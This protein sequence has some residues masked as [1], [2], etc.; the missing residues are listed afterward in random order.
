MRRMMLGISQDFLGKQLGLTFQ[1]VQKYEKG[2]NRIGASRL[3][4]L[5]RIL[6]VS[7]LFFF[8]GGRTTKRG[9]RVQNAVGL[10]LVKG[11][12]QHPGEA[13][14]KAAI[15]GLVEALAEDGEAD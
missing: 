14:S 3:Q 13:N 9:E 5:A 1:Q 8:E 4:H 12:R 2:V 15:V 10:R 6:G 11:V 7:E